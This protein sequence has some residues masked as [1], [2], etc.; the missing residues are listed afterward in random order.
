MKKFIFIIIVACSVSFASQTNAQC[1]EKGKIMIDVYYGWPNLLSKALKTFYITGSTYSGYKATSMGPL[2]GRFEYL[3]GGKIGLGLEVNYANSGI[4]W[5]E[6]PYTYKVSAPRLSIMP[7]FNY[8]FINK[9]NFEM[10]IAAALGYKSWNINFET[11][12]PNYSGNISYNPSSFGYRF[13]W[14][15]RLFFTDNIGANFELGVGGALLTGGLT[16]KF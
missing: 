7:R 10:F 8:H 15:M 12:D 2:G 3:L 13:A 5:T 14:G 11:N 1:L 4:E 16:A 6:T 9:D